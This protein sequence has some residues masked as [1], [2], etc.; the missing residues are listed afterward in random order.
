MITI[1][2][3]FTALESRRM[4]AARMFS[5]GNS[6]ADIARALGVSRQAVS[7]WYHV[8]KR[9]GK[10]G[11]KAAG[12]A[13]RKPK[14]TQFQLKQVENALLKG[15]EYYGYTTQLWTLER[16]ACVI[17][18][19]CHVRYHP[20]HVWRLL[21]KLGWSCQRPVRQ[22]KERNEK[23]IQHWIKFRWPRIKK[24]PADKSNFG[25]SG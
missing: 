9:H 7:I 19:V 18:K 14:L 15:P 1:R 10:K 11:L 24:S 13:G 23:I 20:G 8:W 17:E 16:I 21:G 2:R 3:D 6:Q 25:L 12:R 5:A 4:Q 22:A